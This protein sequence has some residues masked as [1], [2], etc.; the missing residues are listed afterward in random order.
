MGAEA[1]RRV[2]DDY[3]APRRLIKEMHLID[4]VAA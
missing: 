4:R 1:H 2:C 3:L